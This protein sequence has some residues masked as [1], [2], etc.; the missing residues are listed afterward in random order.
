MNKIVEVAHVRG[1]N[2][3]RVHLWD[4]N[5]PCNLSKIEVQSPLRTPLQSP[6]QPA[7]NPPCT[8]APHT[9]MRM[10]TPFM[11]CCACGTGRGGHVIQVPDATD[12]TVP[13]CDLRLTRPI[14]LT[15]YPVT[16]ASFSQT[17]LSGFSTISS[18]NR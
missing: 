16:H 10:R 2:L 7:C 8:T 14:A 4:C 13:V 18:P 6:L 12:D 3:Q 5:L 1:C 9:P 15:G 11:G 17:D